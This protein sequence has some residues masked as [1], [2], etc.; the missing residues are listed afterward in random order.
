MSIVDK[1]KNTRSIIKKLVEDSK[2]PSLS[3]GVAQN[4][5]ILWNEGFGYTDIENK[6]HATEHT[7]YHLA[8]ISK[9]FTATGLM[10]LN[11][12]GKLDL[13]KPVQYYL[14]ELQF[15]Q[16]HGNPDELTIR[17]LANHS[18]GLPIH[19]S[20]HY[21]DEETKPHSTPEV[22]QQYGNLVAPPME[23]CLYANLGYGILGHLIEETSSMTYAEFMEKEVF[24]PLGMDN[25]YT[26]D[27]L[28]D[29][30][31]TIVYYGP[32]DVPDFDSNGKPIYVEYDGQFDTIPYSECDT[33]GAGVV[34]CSVHDL[35]KFGMFHLSG[36]SILSRAG[37]DEMKKPTSA[38]AITNVP[39]GA[40]I[41]ENTM[42]GVGWRVSTLHGY[43]I[44]W[45]DGGMSGASTKLVLV[46]SENLVIV[47]LCNRFQPRVTDQAVSNILTELMQQGSIPQKTPDFLPK[48]N[49]VNGEWKGIIHTSEGKLPLTLWIGDKTY[50][51]LGDEEKQPLFTHASSNDYFWGVLK[52]NLDTPDT[53]RYPHDLRLDLKLRGDSLDGFTMAICIKNPDN[54]MGYA[55]SHW[56]KLMKVL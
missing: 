20:Y 33:P 15:T 24:Q 3:V 23:R 52:G 12:K 35:L 47:A 39:P 13:D 42:Y 44:V 6:S 38:P 21:S 53:N 26:L 31:S 18:S 30:T 34:S 54:R 36:G 55:L 41:D 5:K 37:L 25:S 40:F 48:D 43:D 2:V 9:V 16:H 8:S 10:I 50:S 17:T 4:G 11:E 51:K 1:F 45:H 29:K 32:D 27:N 56:T 46:P 7:S 49:P 19:F 14:P 22:V 28:T